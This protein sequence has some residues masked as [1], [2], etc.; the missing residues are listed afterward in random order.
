MTTDPVAT[1]KQRQN[2]THQ[3]DRAADIAVHQRHQAIHQITGG[4]RR[5][6]SGTACQSAAMLRACT[7]P[8]QTKTKPKWKTECGNKTL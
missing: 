7:N 4:K 6:R 2:G 8:S 5:V 1:A 3:V